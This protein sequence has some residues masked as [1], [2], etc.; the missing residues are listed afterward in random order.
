VTSRSILRPVT[1][2]DEPALHPTK[3]PVPGH[4]GIYRKGPR[5]L[6]QWR[7][8]GRQRA[9]S[10]RTLTEASRFKGQIVSGDTRPT[11]REPFRGYAE[12]WLDTY[13]GRTSRGLSD[14]TRAHYRDA[15]T[16]FA[17]PYFGTAR[18]DEIDPPMVR[19]FID[20]LAA[21]GLA[22]ASVRRYLAP[23]RPMLAT[24]YE[25]GLIRSNPASGVRAVIGDQRVRRRR[26]LTAEETRSLLA[27]MP[28]DHADLAYVLAATGLRISEALAMRW[29]DI[30]QDGRSRPVLVVPKSKTPSGERVVP[31]SPQTVHRL[32]RRRASSQLAADTDAVFPT[33]IG[34]PIDAH[35]Y[36]HRVFKP[37]ARRAGVPWATPHALRHGL[38]SLMAEHGYSP[39]QIAAHLGHADGGVLAL[40]TYIHPDPIDAADFIDDALTDRV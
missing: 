15:V 17:I 9:R 37:A 11:S 14:A 36:R 27:E 31:L 38:A 24:A 29:G 6:V 25:D 3:K 7:H 1:S 19:D 33:E 35:N 4:P 20:H 21:L 30:A 5:Y 10:F 2:L 16:R 18:M 28:V 40:R 39:A 26:Y 34:T 8:K 23:V 32:V 12:R 13:S 22:A